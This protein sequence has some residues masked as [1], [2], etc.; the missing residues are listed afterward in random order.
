MRRVS[1]T[2]VLA[3]VL[4]LMAGLSLR[5]EP[6]PVEYATRVDT[7]SVSVM[8]DSLSAARLEES[9]LAGRSSVTPRVV[10]R[11]DTL[12]LPPDTVLQLVN[13]SGSTLSLGV[14]N[15]VDSL[16]APELHRYDVGA[17][18]DGWSWSSGQLVCDR[19]RLGHLRVVGSAAV[20][21]PLGATARAGVEWA[22]GQGSRWRVSAMVAPS[23][24]VELGVSRG[25]QLF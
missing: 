2:N 15:V 24:V 23:G 10:M 9:W 17:C 6:T 19:A 18:D 1:V 12:V 14:L 7:V 21:Y 3:V 5:T 4:A 11:T 13:V 8:K 22:P 20:L 25:W 16:W